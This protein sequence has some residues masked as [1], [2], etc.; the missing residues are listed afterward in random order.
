M[1][2]MMANAH[3]TMDGAYNITKLLCTIHIIHLLQSIL[4]QHPSLYE[5]LQMFPCAIRIPP[6]VLHSL[7]GACM[8]RRL[9]GISQLDAKQL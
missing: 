5:Q 8:R 2:S 7:Y 1:V 3:N 6:A 9:T 4:S